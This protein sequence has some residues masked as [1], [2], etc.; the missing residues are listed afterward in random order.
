MTIKSLSLLALFVGCSALAQEA[1]QSW[2][3]DDLRTAVHEEASANAG[4]KG[5]V[6]AGEAVEVLQLSPDGEFAE[7][8]TDDIRG[9]VRARYIM[10]APSFRARAQQAQSALNEAQN[11]LSTLQSSQSGSTEKIEQLRQALTQA[12]GEA[13]K[14]KEDLLRLQRASENVVQ[15]DELNN[16]LQSKLV[17]LEQENIQLNQRNERLKSTQDS[18]QLM[19]GGALVVGGMLL[20]WLLHFM[21]N[22]Q[23]RRRTFH[24]F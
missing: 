20:F 22:T 21:V 8:Q 6:M 18:K 17:R 14:A 15:I 13:Q 19:F 16:E 11:E 4:F 2:I 10:D 7:I 9:W 24:D 12:Q 1:E 5:T 23:S 3:S